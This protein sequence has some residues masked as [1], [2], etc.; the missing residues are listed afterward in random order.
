VRV[1]TCDDH[2]LFRG[3]LRLVLEEIHEDIELC[4]ARDCAG[5]LEQ[6]EAN[7]AFDLVLL[8]LELPDRDGWQVLADLRE[9]H[10]RAWTGRPCWRRCARSSPG[11]CTCPPR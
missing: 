2:E 9:R 4:E 6:V 8:D 3:G 1:L 7:P 10:P 11:S 5:A